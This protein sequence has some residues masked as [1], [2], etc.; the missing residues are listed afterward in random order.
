M[1]SMNKVSD[2]HYYQPGELR[3]TRV[4]NLFDQIAKKYDLVN[5]IQ[6]GGLHRWWKHHLIREASVE[7]GNS[8]LDVCCGTGDLSFALSAKGATVTGVDFSQAMLE[9]AHQKKA[10]ATSN[11]D[12]K[13]QPTFIRAD[14]MDLPFEDETFDI[15][16]M[17]Y[18]LRNLSHWEK[19][20]EE[21]HR[22]VRPGG[23]ILILEFG[24]PPNAWWKNM[25]FA[26]LR[27]AVPLIG[28]S[29]A[30]DSAAYQYILTSLHHFPAQRGIESAMVRLGCRQIRTKL[31]LGGVMSLNMA[32]K[33][34]SERPISAAE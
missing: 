31:F 17:A 11:T 28:W 27:L 25:Y 33:A 1:G 10:A 12:P 16:T 34:P 19:G 7:P 32:R 29:V 3:G 26:Y 15:V 4:M 22:I 13:S 2:N 8:A 9:E 5:D 20:L 21:L 24:K 14:A 6:S 23:R 18:G 30:G